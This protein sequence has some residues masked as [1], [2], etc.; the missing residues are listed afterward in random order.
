MIITLVIG[1]PGSGK[2]TF[3]RN[4]KQSTDVCVDDPTNLNK[5]YQLCDAAYSVGN[6]VYISDPKLCVGSILRD[7][8]TLLKKRYTTAAFQFI[9][10]ENNPE[11]CIANAR[12]RLKSEPYK[13]TENLIIK[14]SSQYRPNE[15]YQGKIVPVHF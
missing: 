13:T 7:A 4:T 15:A 2:T 9:F 14:L 6:N 3:V 1:L 5:V 10:F 12:A 8:V 11:Q